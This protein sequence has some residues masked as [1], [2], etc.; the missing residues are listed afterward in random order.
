M[1][2]RFRVMALLIISVACTAAPP[3]SN[4]PPPVSTP[5]SGT[6]LS[7]TAQA[8][9]RPLPSRVIPTAYE[10]VVFNDWPDVGQSTAELGPNGLPV[11]FV[12]ELVAVLERPTAVRQLP[13]GSFLVTEQPGILVHIPAGSS[14]PRPVLDLRMEVLNYHQFGLLGLAVDPEYP[15]EPYIYLAYSRDAPLGGDAPVY[16]GALDDK[17]DCGQ[18]FS[19]Q[20][21]ARLVRYRISGDPL[22]VNGPQEVLADDWCIS[23][24]N[25]S[26]GAIQ[27]GRDGAL[28]VG[29][30][31]GASGAEIDYGQL[32]IPPNA[33]GD[34]ADEG[35]S[36]RSQDLRLGDDPVSLDGTIVRLDRATGTGLTDNP[37]ADS[38][39]ANA[40]RIV[41][42]GLRNPYRFTVRPG[43]DEI[44]V[45]DVGWRAYDEINRIADPV[46]DQPVNLGWPCFEGVA[47]QPDWEAMGSD[48]CADVYADQ[49]QLAFPVFSFA[50]NVT[51][52]QPCAGSS[53]LSAIAFYDGAGFPDAYSGALFFAD[54][55]RQCI[56]V[57]EPAPDGQPD[58]AD[59]RLFASAARAVDIVV[60]SDG[61]LYYVDAIGGELRRIRWR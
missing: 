11:G 4:S 40:R 44:W 2:P 39:D 46:G 33:C 18:P 53:A 36:L 55:A 24:A 23:G 6:E 52:E 10:S 26:I 48:A 61:A 3:L 51:V 1:A 17:F 37:L 41:A 20:A 19:C 60:G 15:A 22:A 50:N 47:P 27:F 29:G 49:S 21:S 32:A 25:H 45:A 7:E 14:T 16:G 58:T 31:D 43:T 54:H 5:P 34:P 9:R 35:G 13:D 57:M 42:F 59:V 8:T 30:G 28:L 12:D 38:S 56:F